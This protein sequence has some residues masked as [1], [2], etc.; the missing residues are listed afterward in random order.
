MFDAGLAVDLMTGEASDRFVAVHDDV[1]YV[2][3]H[4]AFGGMELANG[5]CREVHLKITEQVVAGD[6]RVRIGEI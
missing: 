1:T 5:R 2:L 3:L 6:E 4:V